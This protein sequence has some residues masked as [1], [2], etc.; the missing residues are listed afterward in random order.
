[1]EKISNF[2]QCLILEGDYYP[3]KTI[4]RVVRSRDHAYHIAGIFENKSDLE[5]YVTANP[6]VDLI[7]SDTRLA[8]GSV[9]D[10]FERYDIRT[11]VIF[12]SDMDQDI[13]RGKMFNMVGFI[14]KPATEIQL[15]RTM[16]IFE[17][18]S[19]AKANNIII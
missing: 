3:S 18:M 5:R 12:I 15:A 1:M 16:D 7:I 9:M 2:I 17:K 14:P 10:V 4:E 19:P 13:N 8:D 6:S 11:P